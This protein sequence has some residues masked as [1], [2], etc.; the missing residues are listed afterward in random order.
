MKRQLR[1]VDLVMRVSPL[2][3]TETTAKESKNAFRGLKEGSNVAVHYTAKAGR[4]TA[5]E[6]DRIGKD[7][8]K[9]TEGTVS[10]IESGRQN[11]RR[12]DGRWH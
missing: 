7:G 8:L 11:R 3:G 9:V 4:K 10:H 1:H 2:H 12:Q 5:E 6:V